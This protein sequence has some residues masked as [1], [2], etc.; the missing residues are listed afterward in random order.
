MTRSSRTPPVDRSTD[1]KVGRWVPGGGLPV[2]WSAGRL[3]RRNGRL[4]LHSLR[5]GFASLLIAD[6]LDVVFVSQHLGHANRNVRLCVYA[7]LFAPW[8]HAERAKNR[9]CRRVTR[10]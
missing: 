7:D 3:V 8:E 2:D 10:R 1:R 6:D 5:H 9:P 4:S